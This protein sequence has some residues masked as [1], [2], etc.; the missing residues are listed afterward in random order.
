M[1]AVK[2]LLS[3]R[4]PGAKESIIRGREILDSE[5]SFQTSIDSPLSTMARRID[6]ST[7]SGTCIGF[8]IEP[9]QGLGKFDSYKA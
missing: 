3:K 2:K 6:Y 1:D 4:G 8:Y 9:N 5:G 7:C